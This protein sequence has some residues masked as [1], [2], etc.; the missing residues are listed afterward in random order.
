MADIVFMGMGSFGTLNGF[1]LSEF[2]RQSF[3]LRRGM[4][5]RN[6]PNYLDFLQEKAEKYP[7]I[8]GLQMD[9]FRAVMKKEEFVEWAETTPFPFNPDYQTQLNIL[10]AKY[11]PNQDP[12]P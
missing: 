4:I 12:K 2:Q 1:G 3:E 10:D 5:K 7:D 6:D 8:F 9:V 11:P